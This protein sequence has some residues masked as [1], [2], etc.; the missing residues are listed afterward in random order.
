MEVEAHHGFLPAG[1]Q[2]HLYG[3]PHYQ[4]LG[5]DEWWEYI[6]C[7]FCYIEVEVPFLCDHLQ[8]EH[9]FDIKNAVCPICA[10]NLDEDSEEHF[11]VQHSHLLKRSKSCCKPSPAADKEAYEEDSD[12]EV[13]SHYIGR[14]VPDSS[15]DPLLSL[16]ICCSIAPPIDL[17]RHSEAEVE[18]H[19]PSS[20][21]DQSL[22]AC[23]SRKDQ[24]MMDDASKQ[25]LEEMLQ[26]IEFVKQMLMTTIA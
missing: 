16:F 1:R 2:Q 23:S 4:L 25:E 12:F 15:P 24:G 10:D 14:P 26:R 6:P 20:S 19:V 17:P 9:C 21:D 18:G 11:R 13:P 7:P 5:D 8:E 3:H 22:A